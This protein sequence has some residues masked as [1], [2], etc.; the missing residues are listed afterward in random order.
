MM[1]ASGADNDKYKSAV[2]VPFKLK[3]EVKG[4]VSKTS[5]FFFLNISSVT[6]EV[7]PVYTFK[8]S[9]LTSA[10]LN[11]IDTTLCC[12]FCVDIS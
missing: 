6:N 3:S 1:S 8:V 12:L 11:F 5:L 2:I 9:S 4:F 7:S 10:A